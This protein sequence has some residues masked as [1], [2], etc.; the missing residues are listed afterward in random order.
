VE[1]IVMNEQITLDN[2][3]PDFGD[4]QFKSIKFSRGEISTSKF[5]STVNQLMEKSMEWGDQSLLLIGQSPLWGPDLDCVWL[6]TNNMELKDSTLE[7]S[8]D[9]VLKIGV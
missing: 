3:T 5:T 4:K 8:R 2:Y 1:A 9:F 7:K 6:T